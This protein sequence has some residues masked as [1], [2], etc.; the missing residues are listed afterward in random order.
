MDEKYFAGG[1][2][3]I[4]GIRVDGAGKH[5]LVKIVTLKEETTQ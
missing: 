1:L 2:S 3:N 4:Q 5:G